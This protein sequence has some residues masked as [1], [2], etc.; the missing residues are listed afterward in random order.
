M[1]GFIA[2]GAWPALSTAR[3]VQRAVP[4]VDFFTG[5]VGVGHQGHTDERAGFFAKSQ[6]V[7]LRDVA[8]VVA[9]LAHVVFARFDDRCPQYEYRK[10][11][12]EIITRRHLEVL[13]TYP[14]LGL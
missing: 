14:Q 1:W 12:R 5:V 11:M 8:L 10:V 2:S 4:G 9:P 3:E 7:V 13:L 6:P